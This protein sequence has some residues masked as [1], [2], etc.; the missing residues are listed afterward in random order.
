MKFTPVRK[1]LFYKA[2]FKQPKLT[3]L[4]YHYKQ[5]NRNENTIREQQQNK[6]VYEY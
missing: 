2:I 1:T 4:L 5:I 6:S 3:N